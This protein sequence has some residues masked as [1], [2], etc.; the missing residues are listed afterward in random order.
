MEHIAEFATLKAMGATARDLNTIIISQAIIN[1]LTGFVIGVGLVLMTK[2]PL[3]ET[4]ITLG[5]NVE[6]VGFLL[7]LM[8]TIAIAA[9]YFSVHRIRRLDPATIFR[10]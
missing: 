1:A 8:L 2:S 6:L 3:E 7:V 10:N 5:I 4:G 9:G